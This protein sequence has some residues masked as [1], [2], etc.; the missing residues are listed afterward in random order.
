MTD[1]SSSLVPKLAARGHLTARWSNPS[2]RSQLPARP[3]LLACPA[4]SAQLPSRFAHLPSL[5]GPGRQ[6]KRAGQ[7][8]RTGWAGS[9]MAR[10]LGRTGWAGGQNRPGKQVGRTGQAGGQNRPGRQVGQG[11]WVEPSGDQAP[12]CAPLRPI[13]E[14]RRTTGRS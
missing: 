7:V 14:L 10:Q 8:G 5:N 9:R 12:P 13:L 3:G 4:R 6:A 1:R 2:T 11:G